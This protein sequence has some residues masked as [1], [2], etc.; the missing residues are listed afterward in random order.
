M[1]DL[2]PLSLHL[3]TVKFSQTCKYNQNAVMNQSKLTILLQL[4][5]LEKNYRP[6]A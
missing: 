1:P 6:V 4:M 5:C 3:Q 2:K